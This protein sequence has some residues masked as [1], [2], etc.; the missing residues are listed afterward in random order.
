MALKTDI[1]IDEIG[2]QLEDTYIALR[3]FVWK[4]GA[5]ADVGL[6]VW[7]S[8]EAYKLGRLPIKRLR[9]EIPIPLENLQDTVTATYNQVRIV[10]YNWVKTN[11]LL[12]TEDV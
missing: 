1:F 8:L 4:G 9:Y 7:A 5:H 12:E 2:L 10:V 6:D 3:E 11:A